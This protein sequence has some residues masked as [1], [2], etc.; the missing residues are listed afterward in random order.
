MSRVCQ[1]LVE[2]LASEKNRLHTRYSPMVAFASAWWSMMCMDHIEEIEA[3]IG[4]FKAR[5]LEEL[6]T[7]IMP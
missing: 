4:G 7:G 1:K 3:R 2:Q 5:L 6:S